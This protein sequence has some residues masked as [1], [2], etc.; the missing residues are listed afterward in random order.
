MWAGL[1]ADRK[2]FYFVG[3]TAT[4]FSA[5]KS[6][7]TPP[8]TTADCYLGPYTGQPCDPITCKPDCLAANVDPV[9]LLLAADLGTNNHQDGTWSADG[10]GFSVLNGVQVGGRARGC[11]VVMPGV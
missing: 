9:R 8:Y 2:Y 1:H 4:G 7:N 10:Q 3:N 5:I 6:F 11:H